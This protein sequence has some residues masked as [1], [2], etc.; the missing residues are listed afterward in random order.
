MSL[1]LQ[2]AYGTFEPLSAFNCAFFTLQNPSP[3]VVPTQKLLPTLRNRYMGQ[4]GMKLGI[5]GSSQQRLG[6]LL[7]P[8]VEL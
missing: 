8:D 4:E 5:A 2:T 1:S 3:G 7:P 6:V